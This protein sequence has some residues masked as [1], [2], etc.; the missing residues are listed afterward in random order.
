MSELA[1][2]IIGDSAATPAAQILEGLSESQVH[3]ELPHVPHTIYEELWH[4]AF[5]Q[6]ITLDWIAGTETPYPAKPTDGFPVRAFT[7]SWSELCAR[8]LKSGKQ[9]AAAA[10][11]DGTRLGV[12]VR[13]PSRPGEPVRVMTVREQLESLAAHNSYHLGRIV[14]LRQLQQAWPPASGGFSW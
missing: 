13:C 6:Q 4:L 5:W 9:A 3:R 11:Q 2:A 10:S 12:S 14:L 8:F 1:K 7:E